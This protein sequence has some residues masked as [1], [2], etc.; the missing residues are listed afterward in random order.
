MPSNNPAHR[1]KIDEE[2]DLILSTNFAGG[3]DVRCA[4]SFENLWS[5]P[6]V[7]YRLLLIGLDLILIPPDSRYTYAV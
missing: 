5:I 6:R 3:L 2:E 7:S 1:I 4:I